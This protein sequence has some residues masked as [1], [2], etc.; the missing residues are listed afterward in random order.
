MYAVRIQQVSNAA[1]YEFTR[2]VRCWLSFKPVLRDFV[3]NSSWEA[4]EML[5][6]VLKESWCFTEQEKS[7]FHP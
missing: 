4:V 1:K 2:P 7:Y 5:P 3:S 6:E